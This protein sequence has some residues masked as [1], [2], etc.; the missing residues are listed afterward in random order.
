MWPFNKY[1]YTNYHDLNLQ[2]FLEEFSRI[3]EQWQELYQTMNT[4]KDATT[5]ELE[6]WKTDVES[7]MATWESDLLAQLDVWKA[8]VNAD[9]TA[10]ETALLASLD[11]WKAAFE[12]LFNTTFS[13]LEDIKTDAEAARDAAQAAQAAAE[14]AAATLQLDPTLTIATQAAQ[15]KATGDWLRALMQRATSAEVS[16]ISYVTD[17]SAPRYFWMTKANLAPLLNIT[18]DGVAHDFPFTLAATNWMVYV[19]NYLS[20]YKKVDI[21]SSTGTEHY[22]GITVAAHPG[23]CSWYDVG[24]TA[25]E[26]YTDGITN[27]IV[28]TLSTATTN[29]SDMQTTIASMPQRATSAEVAALTYVTDIETPRYFGITKTNLQPLLNITIDGVTHNFPYTLSSIN[30]MVYVDKYSGSYKKVDIISSTGAEH[31]VGI[32]TA[33]HPGYCSWYDVSYNSLSNALTTLQTDVTSRNSVKILAFGNS[34]TYS[35]LGY[36]PQVL[37]EILP[38]TTLTFAICYASGESSAGHITRW[39]NDTPYTEYSKYTSESGV[40]TNTASTVTGK[41]AVASEE[42]DIIIL[43]ESVA[44]LDN[45]Q[46]NTFAEK[47]MSYAGHPFVFA[48]NIPQTSNRN[49]PAQD[50]LPKY[51][52]IADP[53]E[54]QIA[55]FNDIVEY[56]Q[57]QLDGSYISFVIPGG[58]AVQNAK[59]TTLSN[60]GN[61]GD[62]SDDLTG[63][64]QNGL[65]VLI[66]AYAAAYVIAQWLGRRPLLFSQQ[67]NPT[68]NNLTTINYWTRGTHGSCVGVTAANK[69]LVQRCA[70]AAVKTPFE[71][72]DFS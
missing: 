21:I 69:L 43:Q 72:T 71:Y 12:T 2:Y 70:L 26:S 53:W 18:I 68:D 13:N 30:W 37:R 24:L 19:Y 4:W 59:T 31:Y 35:T 25:S 40:W 47:I 56:A 8:G 44:L 65:P 63:H 52:D 27:P 34:F 1:P 38:D 42:W 32:T 62:L 55:Q 66:G 20:A 58:T 57:A 48:Y 14:A 22:V 7:D 29:I 11:A 45:S 36:L 9:I 33:A 64:L 16:A 46:L 28:S 51:Q 61:E 15:A 50:W 41:N 3:F 17:L 67:Y 6:Q 23:Y 60:L 5:A 39:D 54:R 49:R 10:W